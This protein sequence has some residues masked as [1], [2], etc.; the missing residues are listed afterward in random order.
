MKYKIWLNN[1][2]ENYVK[3]S[4]KYRTYLNYSDIC[5]QLYEE[6]N[7]D[8]NDFVYNELL[9]P[10]F[11]CYFDALTV[12][13][14]ALEAHA[15]NMLVAINRNFQIKLIVA[16]DMESVDKDIDLRDYLG[17][18][19]LILSQNYKCIRKTD[20]NYTIKHSFMFD[21][22]LGEYLITPILEIF[23]TVCGFNK[24]YIIKKIKERNREYI[25][26]LPTD[27]FPAEW[28]NYGNIQFK[29]GEKRPYI[30]HP[31]PKYR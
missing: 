7:K 16:R 29:D 15:Q 20:Y 4:S 26:L 8:I 2:L 14:L 11:D 28:Y 25:R 23:E 12:H 24:N 9:L 3:I 6:S 10:F 1:W 19:S 30:S 13:G 27:Y 31:N 22:K 17:V 18:Q 21:F 5:I